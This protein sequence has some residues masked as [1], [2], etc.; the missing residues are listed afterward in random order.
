M[1]LAGVT[2]GRRKAPYRVLVY[3]TEGIG[4]SSFAAGAP[5]PIFICSEDGTDH[6]DVA[7]FPRIQRWSDIFEAIEVLEKGG[8]P[9]KTL[10]LDTLDWAEPLLWRQLCTAGKKDSIE[11]F[12]YGK[13][14]TAALKEWQVLLGRL[15]Q[16]QTKTGMN[17]VLLAH[18]QKKTFKNPLG[19]DYDR[20]E[21]KLNQKASE[22]CREWAGAVLF[23][24]FDVL[25]SK[26]DKPGDRKVRAFG[27]GRFLYT[28]KQAAFDAK[29]RSN[30]PE[31]IA[32]G[33]AEFEA[34]AQ[35]GTDPASLM[36]RIKELAPQ[37][38][39]DK[40]A[41]ALAF[42][43]ANATDPQKLTGALNR[44]QELIA[45]KSSSTPSAQ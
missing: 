16:L 44:I 9:Y 12:G 22:A 43:E 2:K 28:T 23:A 41:K 13:G 45:E 24:Y 38:D 32:L 30:L 7:R 17:I 40:S 1:N 35:A 21:L 42:A 8:H 19:E 3:G 34:A 5:D 29:N 37:V 27:N 31:S 25:V 14:Y 33:W 18:A 6:L 39:P 4:K 15:D 10:V 20:F 36:A 26:S 11:D